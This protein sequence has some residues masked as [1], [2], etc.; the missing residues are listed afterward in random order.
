MNVL[1]T[2]IT[3]EQIDKALQWFPPDR[4][5]TFGEFQSVLCKCGVPYEISDRATDRILQKCRKSGTHTYSGDK[6]KRTK[7]RAL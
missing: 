3:Q 2:E 7:V 4:S 1:G 6:W 5:F